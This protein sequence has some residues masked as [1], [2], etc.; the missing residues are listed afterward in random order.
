MHL[1]NA[2]LAF[3]P[4]AHVY[5]VYSLPPREEALPT[6]EWDAIRPSL[7]P[8]GWIP[9]DDVEF[10]DAARFIRMDKTDMSGSWTPSEVR[11]SGT[12]EG[13][14]SGVPFRLRI[15]GS[16]GPRDPSPS[17]WPSPAAA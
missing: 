12:R 6:A 4:E 1:P 9:L 15:A 17:R 14:S 13:A 2:V 3:E 10:D 5:V 11:T 16:V 7:E 8:T